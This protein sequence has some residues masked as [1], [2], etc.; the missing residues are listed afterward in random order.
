MAGWMDRLGI[1]A[2]D[3]Q[4]LRPLKQ[5]HEMKTRLDEKDAKDKTD[6]RELEAWRRA[7]RHRDEMKCR[8]CRKKLRVSLELVKNRAECHHIKGRA[9]KAVRYDVRNGLLCCPKCHGLLE[10]NELVIVGQKKDLFTVDGARYINA[11][12]DL[13]FK[14]P[15]DLTTKERNRHG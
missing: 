9:D 8:V 7:V 12:C 1:D 2:E 14:R 4:H 6:D 5:K 11:D 13:E 15:E 10:H 3:V